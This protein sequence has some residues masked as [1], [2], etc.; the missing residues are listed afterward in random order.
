[1][2]QWTTMTVLK[3]I[4]SILSQEAFGNPQIITEQFVGVPGIPSKEAFGSGTSVVFAVDVTVTFTGIPSAEA[5]G[6]TIVYEAGDTDRG[7][8]HRP[9]RDVWIM[10]AFNTVTSEFIYWDSFGGPDPGGNLAPVPV[11]QLTG[12]VAYRRFRN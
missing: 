1:M 11:G 7:Q 2:R 5:F 8:R 12:I 4:N 10:R 9:P 6:S 3:Q